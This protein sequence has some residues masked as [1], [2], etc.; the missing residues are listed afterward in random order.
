[1]LPLAGRLRS[2]II[3]KS[4]S[5]M[6]FS[7]NQ[8][9]LDH[10][11]ESSE[12]NHLLAQALSPTLAGYARAQSQR[13]LLCRGVNHQSAGG[14]G[15]QGDH[16]T[17]DKWRSRFIERGIAGLLDEPR[18]RAPRTVT[19]EQVERVIVKTLEA[20]PR[21]ATHWRA[22]SMRR[23]ADSRGQRCTESGEPS[24]CSRTGRRPSSSP[25]IRS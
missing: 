8:R 7:L 17:V 3:G 22:R 1:M 13:F 11:T 24:A 16:S 21:D 6:H 4:M 20:T 23:P 10:S 25:M 14:G 18:S 12:L 2:P 15:A 9:P 5:C 19:D